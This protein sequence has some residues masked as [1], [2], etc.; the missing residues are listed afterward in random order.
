VHPD[1]LDAAGAAVAECPGVSHC[2]GRAGRPN[3]WF[4]LTVPPGSALGPDGALEALRRLAGAD[5][6]LDLLAVRRYK[7]D[8]RIGPR[9]ARPD[10]IPVVNP[11]QSLQPS[12]DQVRAI[13]AF[14]RPLAAEAEPFAALADEAGMSVDDLLVHGADFLAIGWM[15]RYAAVLHHRRAGSAANVLVAWQIGGGRAELFGHRA[16]ASPSVSHCYQRETAPDWPY[17]LYTMIHGKDE[18][19]AART[20][21][22][23]AAAAGDPPRVELPTLTEYK[24]A[25]VRLFSGDFDTWEQARVPG[26]GG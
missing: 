1:S 22:A 21:E 4:T 2:Y 17:N 5:R 24:K 3:L 11:T 16:A 14:Q 15:R 8:A 9:Q 25:R 26:A 18:T 13:R 23:L 19:A 10:L 12:S 7:L 20:I 6:V